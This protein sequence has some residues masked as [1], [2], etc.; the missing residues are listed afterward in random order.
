M[1]SLTRN[2][3]LMASY[4]IFYGWDFIAIPAIECQMQY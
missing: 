1:K 3:K 2:T 4:Q